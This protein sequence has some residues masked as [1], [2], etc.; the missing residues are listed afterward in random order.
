M[1]YLSVQD[2]WT[3]LR[4]LPSIG[5]MSLSYMLY[6]LHSERSRESPYGYVSFFSFFWIFPYAPA[7]VRNR[8]W[9]TRYAKD[10]ARAMRLFSAHQA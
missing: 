10:I 2:P 9:L 4:L 7:T 3:I 8:S 5:L 1:I 6:F